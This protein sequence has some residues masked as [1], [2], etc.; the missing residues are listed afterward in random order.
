MKEILQQ[1]AHVH[2]FKN[3]DG[4]TI[5]YCTE[6][7]YRKFNQ[8]SHDQVKE[9]FMMAASRELNVK[10]HGNFD[11]QYVGSVLTEYV[12]LMR[13]KRLQDQRRGLPAP[14]QPSEEE[15]QKNSYDHLIRYC[16]EKG[17]MPASW[18][19]ANSFRYMRSQGM[20][21]EDESTKDQIRQEATQEWERDMRRNKPINLKDVLTKH[22]GRQAYLMKHYVVYKIQKV[23][24]SVNT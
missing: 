21:D 10:H 5:Q 24:K 18:D 1:I 6:M 13:E 20:I 2:G 7:I 16:E 3:V 22:S 11:A 17:T 19:W 9:A 14:A 4:T 12:V 15:R 8:L 23:L